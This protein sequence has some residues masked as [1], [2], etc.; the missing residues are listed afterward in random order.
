MLFYFSE[1]G[2]GTADPTRQPIGRSRRFCGKDC[3][4]AA[5]LCAL[6]HVIRRKSI[7]VT[8]NPLPDCR[9]R[10]MPLRKK[11]APSHDHPARVMDV[12]NIITPLRR[13][14]EEAAAA[15]YR[16]LP[17]TPHLNSL[18]K[19]VLFHSLLFGAI[20]APELAVS[21]ARAGAPGAGATS[22]K[23]PL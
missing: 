15:V 7:Y 1:T 19:K 14:C 10:C 6:L 11:I 5:V 2:G 17:G 12:D 18:Q 3:R 16:S 23:L 22:Q 8:A 20:I 4:S 21:P 13:S 9:D